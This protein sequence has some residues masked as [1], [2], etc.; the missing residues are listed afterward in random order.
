MRE[1][2]LLIFQHKQQK[3]KVAMKTR[4]FLSLY[5]NANRTLQFGAM[6]CNRKN[7]SEPKK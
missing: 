7:R 3:K 1:D 6:F 4:D 2:S 5:R